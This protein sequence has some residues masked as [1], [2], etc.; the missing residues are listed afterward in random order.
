MSP[1]PP[2]RTRDTSLLNDPE[3]YV[4][5]STAQSGMLGQKT[6]TSA[7]TIQPTPGPPAQP[8]PLGGLPSQ[9]TSTYAEPPSHQQT[10]Q[11]N[12]PTKPNLIL[13]NELFIS[14]STELTTQSAPPPVP[15]REHRPVI[16]VAPSPAVDETRLN[17]LQGELKEANEK[18]NEY[19]NKLNKSEEKLSLAEREKIRLEEVLCEVPERFC[20]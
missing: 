19:Q 7:G 14:P 4:M 10:Q 9:P 2:P 18:V 5:L 13:S 15:S 17:N 20:G 8:N 12:V 3:E 6:A 16:G 1:A 11:G